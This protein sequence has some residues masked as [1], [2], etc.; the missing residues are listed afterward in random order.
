VKSSQGGGKN[1]EL[2]I[3]T[4]FVYK[5][6]QESCPQVVESDVKPAVGSKMAEPRKESDKLFN[7]I[8]F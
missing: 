5:N 2:L 4:S 1:R 7:K 6:F 3:Y 8:L